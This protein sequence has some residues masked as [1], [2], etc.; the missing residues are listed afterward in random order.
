M[1]IIR[2]LIPML[3]MGCLLF[4]PVMVNRVLAEVVHTD[5]GVIVTHYPRIFDGDGIIDR[6]DD[7]GIVVEDRYY[8]FSLRVKFQ[9]PYREYASKH[10]FKEGQDVAFLLNDEGQITVL[11]SFDGI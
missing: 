7:K 5:E 1:R 4:T 10:A 6:I 9:L 3:F 2:T 11:C 8:P